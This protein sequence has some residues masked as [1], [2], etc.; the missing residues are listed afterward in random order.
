MSRTWV[1]D[2][3]KFARIA[4]LPSQAG[5]SVVCVY[6]IYIYI[7]FAEDCNNEYVL[8]SGSALAEGVPPETRSS[9]VSEARDD[10]EPEPE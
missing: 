2:G 7:C 5:R 9:R 8:A 1:R 4:A 10:G 3:A 6:Y